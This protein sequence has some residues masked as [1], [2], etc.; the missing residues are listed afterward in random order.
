MLVELDFGPISR[1]KSVFIEL[2]F[3]MTNEILI[4]IKIGIQKINFCNQAFPCFSVHLNFICLNLVKFPDITVNALYVIFVL[5][6]LFI[7]YWPTKINQKSIILYT[8][9]KCKKKKMYIRGEC[10]T[11]FNALRLH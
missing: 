9:K 1:E 6:L 11:R 8:A 2:D 3:R 7:A 5:V 10:P 4:A